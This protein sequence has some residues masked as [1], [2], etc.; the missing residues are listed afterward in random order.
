MYR[1]CAACRPV[2]HANTFVSDLRLWYRSL[3]VGEGP[4]LVPSR[5]RPNFHAELRCQAD[6][7]YQLLT[8]PN[9]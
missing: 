6:I 3:S 4:E 2:T 5:G 9:L 1:V 7:E 8:N